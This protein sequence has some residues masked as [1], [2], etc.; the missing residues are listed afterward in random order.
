MNHESAF[1][2][3]I[4]QY[5]HDIVTGEFLNIG[6]ALYCPDS[7]YFNVRILSKYRRITQT[8]PGA[9]GE[10]FK[11]YVDHLQMLFDIKMNEISNRQL[12]LIGHPPSLEELLNQILPYDDSSIFF[13]P[14]KYG[15]T[16]DVDQTFDGLYQRLV[17]KYTS[18]PE[19]KTRGDEDVWSIFRK[20]LSVRKVLSKLMP[21]TVRT[22]YDDIEFDHTWKNGRW[23]ILQPLSFDLSVPTIIKKKA[24][25]WL[26]TVD[27]LDRSDELTNLFLLLGRPNDNK[28]EHLKVYEKSK[29]MLRVKP[30]NYKL[31]LIE[32]NEAEDF[33]RDIAQQIE[34]DLKSHAG[35][36]PEQRE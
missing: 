11:K 16:F 14:V 12:A 33:G 22:P 4:L 17:E 29:S 27:S 15:M 13:G 36:D 2:F 20:P 32:E 10:F 7:S 9:D 25:E 18:D 21:H 19:R 30:R 35:P 26:G 31:V 1:Q 34:L 24:R 23:N 5:R 8:F 3:S 6:L 28:P